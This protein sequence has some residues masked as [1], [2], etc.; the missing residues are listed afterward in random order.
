MKKKSKRGILSLFFVLILLL[1]GFLLFKE[2]L[3]PRVEKVSVIKLPNGHF[4][5]QV[6]KTPYFVKGVV[7]QPIPVGEDYS[8]NF[9]GD[10]AKPWLVD[11]VLMKEAGINTVRFYQPGQNPGEVKE[12][13]GDLY[14]K[15]K[16]RTIMGH[17]LGL[18]D[19]PLPCYAD[20]TYREQ[21]KE[22][23]LKMVMEYKDEPA[24]LFWLLGNENNYSFDDMISPWSS[25]ELDQIDDPRER[26]KQKARIYYSFV[27][28][29]AKEIHKIDPKH[30]V[31][32]GNGEL[33]YLEIAK[34]VAPEVDL[35]GGIFYRGKSF[36]NFWQ[37]LHYKF[38]KPVVFIEFGCDRF[39]AK[40]R[41]EDE[42]IQAHFLEFQWKEIIRNST[43]GRGRG[44]ALGGCIFEWAD[45]WWKHD[46]SNPAGWWVHDEEAG[47]TNGS[48]YFDIEVEGHMNMNE[49]WYGIV[50]L[51]AEKE[52][53][54]NKRIPKRA[55]YVLKDIWSKSPDE[56]FKPLRGKKVD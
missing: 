9:W 46:P 45:E 13:I 44:N 48:Y 16:I 55:Y 11:G 40:T 51:S 35:L 22:D 36:G 15:Y 39:N 33:F 7:Y 37:E 26:S 1:A 8:Y 32:M 27:N 25:E 17:N 23:V 47:W 29:L 5:L 31:A 14:K 53:G 10:P 21:M 30:P 6:G 3:K 49:E 24:I 50:G 43:G 54:V 56:L 12:L 52:N 28:E 20:E 18:Y 2:V 19:F 4:E 42:D 41:K 38:G 34:E